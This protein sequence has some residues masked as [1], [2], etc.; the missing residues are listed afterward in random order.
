M[1]LTNKRQDVVAALKWE[2]CWTPFGMVCVG[3][4][5]WMILSLQWI[6]LGA[7]WLVASVAI[8]FVIRFRHYS[9]VAPR[10]HGPQTYV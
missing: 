10:I 8:D 7:L 3:I 6:A 4:G 9:F 5:L 2:L 1:T